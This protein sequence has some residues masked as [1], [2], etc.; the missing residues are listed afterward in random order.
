[1][2]K[3]LLDLKSESK[4][5]IDLIISDLRQ[6]HAEQDVIF[7]CGDLASLLYLRT[8]YPALSVL[9]RVHTFQEFDEAL[10]FH[11]D[12]IQVDYDWLTESMVRKARANGS[13]VLV[14]TLDKASDVPAM[15]D[16]LFAMGVDII[17]TDHPDQLRASVVQ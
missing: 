10:Q 9:S 6:L 11:P 17:L 7:Q 5:Q 4:E 8:Q 2:S 12:I 13:K 1:H 15:W 14:K 16:Q 3:F